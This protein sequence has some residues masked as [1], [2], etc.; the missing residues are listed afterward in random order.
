DVYP[1]AL[2]IALY[3]TLG[4]L[5]EAL[6]HLADTLREKSAEFADVITMGR[7]QMQD[8]VPMTLG[9][10]FGS[11]AHA[12]EADLE[13]LREVR[14]NLPEVNLG[15]AATG[16]ELNTVRGYTARARQH[17]SE[18]TGL[19]VYTASNLLDATQETG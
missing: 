16:T 7:T 19:P 15:G 17:L 9:P 11:C 14:A 3:R 5:L 2:R 13:L 4:G 10:S 8:A 6:A 18:G 1:S 12:A